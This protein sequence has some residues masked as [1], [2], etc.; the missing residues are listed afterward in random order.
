MLK[1]FLPIF[2]LILFASSAY[3]AQGLMENWYRNDDISELSDSWPASCGANNQ[4]NPAPAIFKDPTGMAPGEHLMILGLQD[5][6]WRGYWWD[7][8]SRQW[9]RNDVIVSG[10]VNTGGWARP[11]IFEHSGTTYLIT[12]RTDGHFDGYRLTIAGWVNDPIDDTLPQ[13]C[14]GECYSSPTVGFN[15]TGDGNLTLIAGNGDGRLKSWVY[16]GGS[17]IEKKEVLTNLGPRIGPYDWRSQDPYCAKTAGPSA[18]W[19]FITTN[20]PA[21]VFNATGNAEWYIAVGVTQ[22]WWDCS[23]ARKSNHVGTWKWDKNGKMWISDSTFHTGVED[24]SNGVI[25]P[26]PNMP[27]FAKNVTGRDRTWLV[28]G[29]GNKTGVPIP[30]SYLPSWYWQD[31]DE[32]DQANWNPPM[33]FYIPYTEF[34]LKLDLDEDGDCYAAV[35]KPLQGYDDM[36]TNG[37]HANA[38]GLFFDCRGDATNDIE[39]D[40]SGFKD[41]QIQPINNVTIACRDMNGNANTWQT[42]VTLYYYI[43][44][45]PPLKRNHTQNLTGAPPSVAVDNNTRE[46]VNMSA[47]AQDTTVVYAWLWTNESGNPGYNFTIYPWHAGPDW[48]KRK[49]VLIDNSGQGNTPDPVRNYQIYI[50]VDY[51][52]DM[53]PDFS[54]I[55]FYDIEGN[56]LDYWIEQK[57]DGISAQVYINLPELYSF[58]VPSVFLYYSNQTAVTSESNASATMMYYRNLTGAV[59][60]PAPYPFC[61]SCDNFGKQCWG[62]YTGRY[63][64]ECWEAGGG[65]GVR[66][67]SWLNWDAGG[68]HFYHTG[69]TNCEYSDGHFAEGIPLFED[70]NDKW[71]TRN[72]HVKVRMR[73]NSIDHPDLSKGSGF[74]LSIDNKTL[75]NG[76]ADPTECE[77]GYS[78][79]ASFNAGVLIGGSVTKRDEL[80]INIGAGGPAGGVG[81][82]N[83]GTVGDDQDHLVEMFVR[84]NNMYLMVDGIQYIETDITSAQ[85]SNKAEWKYLILSE[86]QSGSAYQNNINGYIKEVYGRRMLDYEPYVK[87]L[88]EEDISVIKESWGSPKIITTLQEWGKTDFI[89]HNTSDAF[90]AGTNI[91]WRIWYKDAFDRVVGT[92]ILSFLIADPSINTEPNMNFTHTNIQ[93]NGINWFA[94]KGVPLDFDGEWNGIDDGC[95]DPDDL[96]CA[97]WDGYLP[98]DPN[99]EI[100]YYIWNNGSAPQTPFRAN[101]TDVQ[102]KLTPTITYNS[103]GLKTVT[104]WANDTLGASNL[105]SITID[106][107]NPPTNDYPVACAKLG[108]PVNG[109]YLCDMGD[110]ITLSGNSSHDSLDCPTGFDS[111]DFTKCNLTYEWKIDGSTYHTGN[112]ENGV[113]TT[114]LCD[115]TGVKIVRLNVTDYG[116]PPDFIRVDD[117][118]YA[119]IEVRAPAELVIV[120]IT[121]PSRIIVGAQNN[122]TVVI[123]NIGDHRSDPIILNYTLVGNGCP[124]SIFCTGQRIIEPSGIPGGTATKKITV[125]IPELSG[126]YNMNFQVLNTSFDVVNHKS[127]KFF[128]EKQAEYTGSEYP[129]WILLIIVIALPALAYHIKKQD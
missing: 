107:T 129:I 11:T 48:T 76:T 13:Y 15:V 99:N 96:D 115:T 41:W 69:C 36:V 53:N 45:S 38:S 7:N 24:A 19:Q 33:G 23:F 126:E 55:R 59:N 31:E 26:V 27:T 95:C 63:C 94:Y 114:Y 28:M 101:A 1:K 105:T 75:Y 42:A 90:P 66:P 100:E 92:P 62:N 116:T 9:Q 51:D 98:T 65:S 56:K 82:Y 117:D 32:P 97:N 85:F 120:D 20:R 68:V 39:C 128:V 25:L 12:G 57:T 4:C 30:P 123:S 6:S 21:L 93:W 14:N 29:V 37:A 102:V 108:C 70:P 60:D 46:A 86:G 119:T 34:T 127:V 122:F 91:T 18:C 10:L 73:L 3:A 50:T 35:N 67:E 87:M 113:A 77:E 104:L 83:N 43:D 118:D 110:T 72:P 74:G 64:Q 106:I 71:T 109:I 16:V 58:S 40:I 52:S 78:I 103:P 61:G 111:S 80:T 54:D 49:E 79:S 22:W 89:W 44:T 84:R 8:A 121:K 88:P 17:W 125:F 112:N 81:S 124:G 2:I 47:M 5:G